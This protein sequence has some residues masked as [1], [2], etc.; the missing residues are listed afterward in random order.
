M[1]TNVCDLIGA[2]V[3]YAVREKLIDRICPNESDL[4]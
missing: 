3:E 4:P 2:L 1:K